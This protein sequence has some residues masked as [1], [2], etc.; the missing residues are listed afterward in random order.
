FDQLAWLA[1]R[2]LEAVLFLIGAGLTT[3]LLRSLGWRPMGFALLLWLAVCAI[4]LTLARSGAA[5]LFT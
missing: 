4:S 2:G 1:R 3:T 5:G